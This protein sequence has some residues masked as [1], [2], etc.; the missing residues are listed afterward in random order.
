MYHKSSRRNDDTF[1]VPCITHDVRL[2]VS[3]PQE[4]V[5]PGGSSRNS[6]VVQSMRSLNT[7]SLKPP[8]KYNR[9]HSEENAG[10]V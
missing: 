9:E 2:M 1:T 7:V 5:N 4:S 8:V 3:G 10:H 6:N